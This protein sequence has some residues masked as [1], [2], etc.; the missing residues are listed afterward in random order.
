MACAEQRGLRVEKAKR[1]RPPAATNGIAWNGFRALLVI[2]GIPGS[3]VEKS[4]CPWRSTTATDPMW[5]LSTASPR[6]T[7]T[8]GRMTPAHGARHGRHV[9]Q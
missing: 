3:P 1:P 6:M 4:S 2:V 7:A 5:T 8:S 9:G